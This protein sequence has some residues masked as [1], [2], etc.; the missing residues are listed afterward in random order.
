MVRRTGAALV[1]APVPSVDTTAAGDCFTGALV[2]ALA[3]GH[4]LP[5]AVAFACWAAA[6]AVTRPGA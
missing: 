3:E 4:A 2:V 5:A 1:A 6:L